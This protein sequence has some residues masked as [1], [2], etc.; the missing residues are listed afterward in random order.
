MPAPGAFVERQ[1]GVGGKR[2]EAH[3][4]D[5]EDAGGVGLRAAGT[6]DI[7]A[8][9]MILDVDR[10]DRM[11]DPLVVR[12]VE[13]EL[14]AE[15]TLVQRLLRT[16]VDDRTL[17]AREGQFLRIGLDEILALKLMAVQRIQPISAPK[18]RPGQIQSVETAINARQAAA[19][20]MQAAQAW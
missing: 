2:A 15:G 18:T 7:D 11:V 12:F 3:C 4:R 5:V 16:L 14:G 13:V 19:R 6:A 9:I 1:D 8:E 17:R 10:R 20:R